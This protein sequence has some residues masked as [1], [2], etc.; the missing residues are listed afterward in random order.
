MTKEYVDDYLNKYIPLAD[1]MYKY[2]E[3]K[4]I[5]YKEFSDTRKMPII[6]II[7]LFKS[8]DI[9]D[10]CYCNIEKQEDIDSEEKRN[11]T[12]TY[13]CVIW[14]SYKQIRA[15]HT[16]NENLWP[17]HK[18]N[19]WDL[20]FTEQISKQVWK[21]PFKSL[22][23]K[24]QIISNIITSKKAEKIIDLNDQDLIRISIHFVKI[25]NEFL[26]SFR[27][28]LMPE[29]SDMQ[30]DDETAEETKRYTSNEDES[31]GLP[32]EGKFKSLIDFIK[33]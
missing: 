9:K 16:G 23:H 24:N 1:D 26:N 22:F 10:S 27:R 20:F 17:E 30:I 13:K 25:Y 6:R 19:E 14:T 33:D 7:K 28:N 4:V 2:L 29:V 18:D 32:E 31:W 15:I 11:V 12:T 3:E 5:A 8:K 21:T